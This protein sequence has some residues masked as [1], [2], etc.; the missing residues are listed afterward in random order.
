M[1]GDMIEIQFSVGNNCRA[2]LT[3]QASTKV[4]KSMPSNVP[5]PHV[6]SSERRKLL[7]MGLLFG[8]LS[9][10]FLSVDLLWG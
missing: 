8:R 7:T 1:A 6:R 2:V 5:R 9:F 3:T 10:C 4:F